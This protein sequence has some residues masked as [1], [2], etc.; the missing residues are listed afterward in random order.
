MAPGMRWLA[1]E[2]NTKLQRLPH[3]LIDSN[4][5]RRKPANFRLDDGVRF[6]KLDVKDYFMTGDHG[7]LAQQ[8][9]LV[10]DVDRRD[11]YR[12]VASAIL[13]NQFVSS[14]SLPGEVFEVTS[15][16]GMGMICS[17]HIADAV[18]HNSLEKNFILKTGTRRK[19]GIVFYARFKDDILLIVKSHFDDVRFLIDQMRAK[20]APFVLKVESS[21]KQGCQMLDLDVSRVSGPRN[22]LLSFSLFTKPSNI[23]QPLSPE[24]SHPFSVH[25]FWPLAQ[26][27]RI[28]SKHS[29]IAEGVRAVDSFKAKYFD[30]FG[31]DIT[32][33][34]GPK[35]PKVPISW[36]VLP[37]TFC[38][39]GRLSKTV[40]SV[41][42]PS[43]FDLEKVRLS[44]ELGNKHLMHLLRG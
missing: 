22:D 42:V 21:S 6:I 17:G 29:D 32:S 28:Y 8:S 39:G 31:V 7:Y 4:D 15:G 30:L 41:S 12:V 26:C 20:A 16:T 36:L 23:W 1:R 11:D 33:R 35:P 13:K 38:F 25:K 9:S 37:V 14:K 34:T 18:L 24:S 27:K 19:F 40:S 3:L 5:L 10:L 44:W 2:L 43:G